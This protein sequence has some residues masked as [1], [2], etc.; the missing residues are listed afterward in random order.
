MSESQ[1][2]RFIPFLLTALVLFGW[3]LI[4]IIQTRREDWDLLNVSLAGLGI[5]T[6]LYLGSVAL[7][8]SIVSPDPAPL[9]YDAIRVT[10]GVVAGVGLYPTYRNVWQALKARRANRTKIKRIYNDGERDGLP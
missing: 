1:W 8:Y 4:V 5:L 3:S 10:L 7:D 2:L 9:Y 6:A